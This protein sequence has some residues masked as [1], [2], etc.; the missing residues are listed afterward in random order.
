MLVLT[1]V[2]SDGTTIWRNVSGLPDSVA[3]NNRTDFSASA[4]S[5]RRPLVI[6][7]AS[8][9]AFILLAMVLCA[10]T[11]VRRK[12]AAGGKMASKNDGRPLHMRAS[13]PPRARIRVPPAEM[14]TKVFQLTHEEPLP[15]VPDAQ[16]SDA[17]D[18]RDHQQAAPAAKERLPLTKKGLSHRSSRSSRYFGV[19]PQKPFTS[20]EFFADRFDVSQTDFGTVS[21]Q[22]LTPRTSQRDDSNQSD[23]PSLSG[24]EDEPEKAPRDVIEYPFALGEDYDVVREQD[25]PH[26]HCP[27]GQ[28]VFA[29]QFLPS[30]EALQ[31]DVIKAVDLR[32]LEG[33][34]R[35][36]SAYV[37]VLIY[38][39]GSRDSHSSANTG[40]VESNQNPVFDTS[41]IFP[42]LTCAWLMV[43][44]L[45]LKVLHCKSPILRK[46]NP[47]LGEA[48]V[49]F[50][51]ERFNLLKK[52]TLT[53]PLQP[54]N[55]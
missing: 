15:R 1:Q 35:M 11:Y 50:S 38:T 47:R 18:K 3:P 10:V 33:S 2:T 32:L 21:K 27:F 46:K 8:A 31:V 19:A 13:P 39:Q 30:K 20:T 54:P 37:K 12:R 17:T 23:T 34:D 22:L 14:P 43:A 5:W 25:A 55:R 41:C 42:H 52:T 48:V 7:A 26:P 49:D 6:V 36:P 16:L 45:K 28:I 9:S 40:V 4:H 29:F 53:L 24:Y 44:R 51:K